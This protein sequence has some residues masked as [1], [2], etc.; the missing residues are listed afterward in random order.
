MEWLPLSLALGPGP[1]GFRHG[2]QWLCD[3]LYVVCTTVALGW[4]VSLHARA[5][6]CLL[7]GRGPGTSGSTPSWGRLARTCP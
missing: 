5:S 7:G 1:L 3:T 6:R 4:R 2:R